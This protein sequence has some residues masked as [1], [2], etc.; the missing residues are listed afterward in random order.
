MRVTTPIADMEITIHRLS[1]IGS[2]LVMQ[3]AKDDAIPTRAEM[4]PKDVRTL[5]GFL[6]R[7]SILIFGLKCLF[8]LVPDQTDQSQSD[9]IDHPTPTPW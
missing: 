4:T 9:K 1:V 3:N 7:P 6:F 8:G 2:R 5:F